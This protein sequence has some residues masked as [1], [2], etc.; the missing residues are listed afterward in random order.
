MNLHVNLSCTVLPVSKNKNKKIPEF[1]R[2]YSGKHLAFCTV[3]LENPVEVVRFFCHRDRAQLTYFIITM[4]PATINPRSISRLIYR[5]P[6]PTSP[7]P[8][9]QIPLL[10]LTPWGKPGLPNLPTPL[11]FAFHRLGYVGV[12]YC[13]VL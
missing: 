2:R 10:R 12:L 11:V 7:P 5:Y 6:P 4:I 1:F 9:R 13:T 3:R 8:P